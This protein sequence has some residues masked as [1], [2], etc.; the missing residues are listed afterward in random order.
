MQ[1]I[2]IICIF[3]AN[4]KLKKDG[5]QSRKCEIADAQRLS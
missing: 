4:L 2:K 5:Y 1:G 3:A